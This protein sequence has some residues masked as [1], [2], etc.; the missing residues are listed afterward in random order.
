MVYTDVSKQV[1]VY[2]FFLHILKHFEGLAVTETENKP[3]EKNQLFCFNEAFLVLRCRW[4]L[5]SAPVSKTYLA[6]IVIPVLS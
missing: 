3:P 1:L 4:E 5:W 6:M 2:F